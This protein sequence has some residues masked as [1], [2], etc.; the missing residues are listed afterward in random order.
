[1]TPF[2]AVDI[3]PTYISEIFYCFKFLFWCLIIAGTKVDTLKDALSALQAA[4][5][6]YS[7]ASCRGRMLAAHAVFAGQYPESV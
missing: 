4:A 2:H 7:L 5:P 6:T 1:M 3:P